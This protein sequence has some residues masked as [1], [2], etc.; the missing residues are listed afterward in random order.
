MW[1]PTT[2]VY[3]APLSAV[4]PDGVAWN[5][6]PTTDGE[7]VVAGPTLIADARAEVLID[8]GD[9]PISVSI[10]APPGC[11]PA[12]TVAVTAPGAVVVPGTPAGEPGTIA[13]TAVP[14]SS[15]AIVE[16]GRDRSGFGG[17]VLILA[18][19][20]AVVV[21]M[22]GRSVIRDNRQGAKV[23]PSGHFANS[24]PPDPTP[25]AMTGPTTTTWFGTVRPADEW[26]P[27]NPSTA[28][29]PDRTPTRTEPAP[30]PTSLDPDDPA[31]SRYADDVAEWLQ[32]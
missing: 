4:G 11:G 22:I 20:A 26:R 7:F 10:A 31:T 29:P 16:D 30:P 18:L 28:P 24:P 17:A 27:G 15:T 5:I 23:L 21:V 32:R 2:P 12:P 8:M 1:V 25:P 6:L 13:S 19:L 14:A 9:G 3:R